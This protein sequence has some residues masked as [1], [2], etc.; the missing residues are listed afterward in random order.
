MPTDLRPREKALCYGIE[1]LSN[2]ELF[3]LILR[4]GNKQSTVSQIASNLLIYCKSLSNLARMTHQDLMKISGIKQ[5]KALELSSILE[6]SKRI[7]REKAMQTPL[8]DNMDA[9]VNWCK[10]EIGYQQQESF[11][12]IYLSVA[13]RILSY[14]IVFKGT[15]D[16]SLIHPR[17]IFLGA[18]KHH[19]ASV[20]AVHNH[21]AG[22]LYPSQMDLKVTQQLLE[23]SELLQIPLLDHLIVTSEGACSIM[24]YL[25][26]VE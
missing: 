1:S 12:V 21:P 5:A 18:I 7:S 2:H 17:E 22:T 20:I 19:A 26:K 24:K 15:L 6:L 10:N 13:S 25:S 16:R 3:M 14:E 8:L 4:H 23:A 9:V 11:L